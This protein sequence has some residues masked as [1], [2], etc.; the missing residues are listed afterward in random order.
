[1]EL[2]STDVKQLGELIRGN[3]SGGY[4]AKSLLKMHLT[5]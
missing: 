3:Q 1:M 5:P 2:P 4:S